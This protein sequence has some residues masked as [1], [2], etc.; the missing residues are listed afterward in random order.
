MKKLSL[1]STLLAAMALAA[2]GGANDKLPA[3]NSPATGTLPGGSSSSVAPSA[4]VLRGA[5]VYRSC[6]GCHG[7]D[8]ANK[9]LGIDK[10]VSPEALDAAYQKVAPMSAFRTS[11]SAANNA[12]LAAYI[13]SRVSPATAGAPAPAPAPVAASTCEPAAT[14]R[15]LTQVQYINALT[16]FVSTM[17]GDAGLA[18][19]VPTL[20]RDTAQLPPDLPIDPEFPKH[21]GFT[22]LDQSIGQNRGTAVY[23]VAQSLSASMTNTPERLNAVLGQCS[24][25]AQTCLDNFIKKAGR[26]LYRKPLADAEVAALRNVAAG[27]TAAASVQKV[28]GAMM[29]SPQAYFVIERAVQSSQ[30]CA[31]LTGPELASRLALHFWDSIPDQELSDAAD[32]PATDN[33]SL[34]NATGYA[35]Q[36][37]RL[38]NDARADATM[39]SFFREWFRLDELTSSPLNGAVGTVKFDRFAA[40]FQ[41]TAQYHCERDQRSARHGQPTSPRQARCKTSSPTGSPFART[42]DIA[43]LYKTPRWDGSAT[44]PT[45]TEP[46]REGL[47]GRIAFIANGSTDTTLPISRSVKI[48]GALT[49]QNLG[50]PAI[51]QS[52]PAGDG[53]DRPHH[54]PHGEPSAPPS[55]QAPCA[56]PA[57]SRRSTPG[58]LRW[59]DLTHSVG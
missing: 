32:K 50:L 46:E 18:A 43:T 23:S 39:R 2:C 44:P 6:V 41:P 8:P 12:D 58:A 37:T 11:L 13:R 21:K 56:R 16:Q 42:D 7:S 52:P 28:L 34:L 15:R 1:V 17:T 5:E 22:R 51:D 31:A 49:C 4:E 33:T 45:F 3:N 55:R 35:A 36:V 10:G 48:L 59:S 40:G 27:S 38:L 25:S 20:V 19:T 24:A 47:F 30:T 29:A 26:L 9:S 14:P 53:A 54:H 57:T